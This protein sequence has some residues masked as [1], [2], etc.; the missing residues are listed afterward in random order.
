MQEKFSTDDI[1]NEVKAL[2]GDRYVKQEKSPVNNTFDDKET[3]LADKNNTTFE[4]DDFKKDEHKNPSSV[5]QM[6]AEEFLKMFDKEEPKPVD[7]DVKIVGGF[8]V[9]LDDVADEPEFSAPSD[10]EV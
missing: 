10:F 5:S 6:S 8:K 2:S 1:L 9:Q 3:V 4:N 7:E